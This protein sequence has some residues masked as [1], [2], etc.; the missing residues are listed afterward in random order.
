MLTHEALDSLLDYLGP[1]RDAAGARYEEIRSRL[2]RLFQWR[3][4]DYPEEL[5]DETMNRVADKLSGGLEIR[6]ADPFRYFCGVA[7]LIFKEILRHQRR[8]RRALEEV[9]HLPPPPDEEDGD[10]RMQ[11][12]QRCLEELDP[13]QRGLVIDYQRGN[14]A[15]RI[16][17]RKRLAAD[18]DIPIN[19]LRIRVHRIR[20]RLESCVQRLIRDSDED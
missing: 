5:A 13:D 17:N 20:V 19:A 11:W 2:I 18:L 14:G 10:A 3:G 6:A 7:H 9:R 15:A 12:L 4:C 16:R 1:D 8:E